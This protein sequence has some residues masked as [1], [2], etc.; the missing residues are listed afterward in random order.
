MPGTDRPKSLAQIEPKYPTVSPNTTKEYRLED[1]SNLDG[2]KDYDEIL[3]SVKPYRILSLSPN[4]TSS[5]VTI[6]YSVEDVESAYIKILNQSTGVSEDY[7]IDPSLNEIIID[8]SF[9]S[10]GLYSVVLVCD[11]EIQDVKNLGKNN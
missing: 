9:K 7:I 4:P 6:N 8:M 3:V 10:Y 2:F 11:G 5:Q 1:I